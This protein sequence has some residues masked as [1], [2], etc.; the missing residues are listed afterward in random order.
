MTV[1]TKPILQE[2][3]YLQALSLARSERFELPTLGFEV[4]CSI[5]LSYE[6]LRA[7][8][9]EL[10]A[11]G[12]PQQNA[13]AAVRKT[14]ALKSGPGSEAG[15]PTAVLA[16]VGGRTLRTG[17]IRGTVVVGEGAG[18]RPRPVIVL[19]ADFVGQSVIANMVLVSPRLRQT[20]RN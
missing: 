12:Y 2:R 15:M 18:Q 6:R 9:S 11:Q 7:R 19:V 16:D 20:R 17:I 3:L 8:L 5:Q 14:P 1:R 10:T 4:R 13:A